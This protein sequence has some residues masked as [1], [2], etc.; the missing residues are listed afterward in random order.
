MTKSTRCVGKGYRLCG[1]RANSDR[2]CRLCG[3]RDGCDKG[4]RLFCVRYS[5]DQWCGL[6]GMRDCR[7]ARYYMCSARYSCDRGQVVWYEE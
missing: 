7:D 2:C 4:H 5:S 3:M 1:V 6:C